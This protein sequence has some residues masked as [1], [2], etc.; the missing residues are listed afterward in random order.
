MSIR[1]KLLAMT[2]LVLLMPCT[3]FTLAQ[4]HEHQHSADEFGTVHF[5]ISGTPDVQREFDRGV[6]ILH[7]FGYELARNVFTD[8]AGKDPR[9]AMAQWGIAMSWYHPIW[10]PP[11][12][13]E[14]AQGRAA[15]EKAA[16]LGAPTDRER[17]Y[18]AAI[19]SFYKDSEIV[20]H[21]TRAAAWRDAM[22]DLARRFPED[23]EASLFYALALLG[24][25]PPSDATFAQQ[26]Q[27]AE[28]LNRMLPVEPNHPGVAHYLIHAFDYPQLASLALPAARSYAKIAPSSAHA[29]HMPSH[30]FTR[31]G[32]WDESIQSNLVSEATANALV[33]KLHPGAASF[34]AL[35]ALDYLEYA[36][37]QIGQ[38]EKAKHVMDRALASVA[39]DEPNFAAAYALAAIPARYAIERRQW[40]D[41]ARLE[42]PKLPLPWE[43][44]AYVPAITHFARAIGAA[45]S[46]KTA[47]AQEALTQLT[48]TRDILAK[49]PPAG[50]YDWAGLVESLRLAAAGW[51][52]QSLGK[53]VEAVGL[54]R[55]AADLQDKVGK[56]PVTPGEIVPARELLADLLLAQG[57]PAEALK[58][59]ELDL[60]AAPNRFNGL[61][62]AARAA[63]LAGDTAASRKLF[64]QL[65]AQC[66]A[67]GEGRPELLEARTHTTAAQR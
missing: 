26:K 45:R 7:S 9:C 4:E 16:A 25:A 21:R 60:K 17:G 27:A 53:P 62:G 44:Y 65:V 33:A 66:G 5:A 61:Y 38:D 47:A 63:D 57:Q 15:A 39:F 22:A 20:D 64:A 29:Q 6:A 58:E 28:I 59:Y 2:G 19:G 14:L 30:I 18:I 41:A 10:A 11:T 8:I 34:D 56:H 54:L 52:A 24:S 12:P 50:P 49:A 55:Q 46:G 67:A 3:A 37:L 32:L 48:S 23:H 35:H 42:V 40:S 31:L 36:Y 13:P 43:K 1:H 51:I